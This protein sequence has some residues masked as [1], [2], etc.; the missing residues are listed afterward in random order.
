MPTGSCFPKT[1]P[2]RGTTD[3]IVLPEMFS[4]G[5]SMNADALAE[6]MDGPTVR[7]LRATANDL[8]AVVTGSFICKEE[9]AI[10]QPFG[11]GLPRWALGDLR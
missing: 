5:F 9:G 2:L 1:R 8:N 4:T 10:L 11:L 6:P 3:L 7:W